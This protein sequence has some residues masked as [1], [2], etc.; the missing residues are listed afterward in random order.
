WVQHLLD[1]VTGTL[2]PVAIGIMFAWV[3]FNSNQAPGSIFYFYGY[4]DFFTSLFTSIL[5][6]ALGVG[7]VLLLNIIAGRF[8]LKMNRFMVSFILSPILF[9]V[10]VIV[11]QTLL[12]IALK[13]ASLDLIFSLLAFGSLYA[14]AFLVFLI[15]V[16]ALSSRAKN[17]FVIFYGSVFGAIVGLNAPSAVIFVLL[18]ALAVED[19]LIVNSSQ[20]PLPEPNR[21]ESDPYDYLRYKTKNV[22]V[23]VGDI[24]VFSVIGAHSF[25]FFPLPIAVASIGML[26]VGIIIL[27]YLS[28]TKDKIMPGLFIPSILSLLPWVVWIFLL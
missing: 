2:L 9:I 6:T 13:S 28:I 11:I 21:F 12:F 4:S 8:S 20:A 27:V 7:I 19:Y 25:Y 10:M 16:D 24:I 1:I 15:S 23:G 5:Y 14:S 3:I 22:I 17:I 26:F 18:I